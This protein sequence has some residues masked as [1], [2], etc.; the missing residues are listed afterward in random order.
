MINVYLSKSNLASSGRISEARNTLLRDPRVEVS[1]HQGG[2]YN[3]QELLN[4]DVLFLVVSQ[5]VYGTVPT[6]GWVGRG[7]YEQVKEAMENDI[8][9]YLIF[10]QPRNQTISFREVV[11][12]SID[13]TDWKL[14]FGRVDLSGTIYY[15]DWSSHALPDSVRIKTN[16]KLRGIAGKPVPLRDSLSNSEIN[17]LIC[18]TYIPNH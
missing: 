9:V 17:L 14:N 6:I 5:D 13:G 18:S 2:S 12:Y 7:Q 3:N 15:L 4:S 8:P 11:N 1:E 16:E 10:K